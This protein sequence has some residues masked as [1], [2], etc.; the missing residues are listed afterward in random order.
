MTYPREDAQVEANHNRRM[1]NQHRHL[2][3]MERLEALAEPM[4]G[5]LCREGA[6]VYYIN[7]MDRK[8]NY[9][10]KTKESRSHYELVSYLIRNGYVG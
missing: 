2:V 1:A 3:R 4:V 7:M 8:G 6:T 5:E 9:T 10:G